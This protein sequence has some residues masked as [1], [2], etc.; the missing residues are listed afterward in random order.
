LRA[1]RRPGTGPLRGLIA[2]A[3]AVSFCPRRASPRFVAGPW[4][5]AAP[6][7]AQVV[8]REYGEAA[9][10]FERVLATVGKE[11]RYQKIGRWLKSRLV[12]R[13]CDG[14]DVHM[15]ALGD[16]IYRALQ[17]VIVASKE[18]EDRGLLMALPEWEKSDRNSTVVDMSFRVLQTPKPWDAG[19]QQL[20]VG[21]KT[22]AYK[23]AGAIAESLRMKGQAFVTAIGSVPATIALKAVLK[24]QAY[25]REEDGTARVGCV[26]DLIKE[27]GEMWNTTTFS[28]SLR[29]MKL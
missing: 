8:R 15:Q 7:R 2:L 29:I 22:N 12:E 25:L 13:E 24:S 23:L 9:G 27:Q 11:S 5:I 26:P 4:G 1:A 28:L 16:R 19:V 6:P 3:I 18:L 21:R 17:A 20:L 10:G 14:E